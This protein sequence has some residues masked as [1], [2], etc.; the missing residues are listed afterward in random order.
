MHDLCLSRFNAESGKPGL[1]W[2]TKLWDSLKAPQGSRKTIKWYS[3]TQ[4]CLWILRWSRHI[5]LFCCLMQA[6][7]SGSA[8][9]WKCWFVVQQ[10]PPS[11][12]RLLEAGQRG[13]TLKQLSA[14]VDSTAII[15]NRFVVVNK[16]NLSLCPNIK[17]PLLQLSS[18]LECL[19][20][21]ADV[22]AC[23]SP[24]SSL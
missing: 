13:V 12:A 4:L 19:N 18:P 20:Y 2:F 7:L 21:P 23:P 22:P 17:R 24:E 5:T 14:E 3:S 10:F 16:V 8:L 1:S 11:L 9:L 6:A 15:F